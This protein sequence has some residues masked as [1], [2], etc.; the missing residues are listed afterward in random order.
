MLQKDDAERPAREPLR[1]LF[2]KSPPHSSLWPTK[3]LADP[4]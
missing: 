1:Q 2:D 3:M 4:V